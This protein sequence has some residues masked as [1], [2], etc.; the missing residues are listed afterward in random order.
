MLVAV[1]AASA[2]GCAPGADDAAPTPSPE[3]AVRT[4]LAA[5]EEGD[6]ADFARQLRAAADACENANAQRQLATWATAAGKWA[7][8]V[9]TDR[10]KAAA[11]SEALLTDVPLAATAADC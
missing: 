4:A 3:Q 8:S 11:R 9:A 10:P 6:L 7:G 5:R 2:V 1:G